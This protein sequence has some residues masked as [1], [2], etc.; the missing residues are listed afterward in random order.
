MLGGAIVAETKLGYI[1]VRLV[2]WSCSDREVVELSIATGFY[3]RCPWESFTPL[4]GPSTTSSVSSFSISDS[5][6]LH[7]VP[8]IYM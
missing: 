6:S 4:A 2:Q 1:V 7:H 3:C 8:L 5:S